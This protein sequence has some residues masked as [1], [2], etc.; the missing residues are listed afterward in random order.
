MNTT[1]HWPHHF[2]MVAPGHTPPHHRPTPENM[3]SKAHNLLRMAALGLPV[4]P[5]LV[6]GTHYTHA[7]QDCLL[8][9]YSVGLPALEEVTGRM[10][11]DPRRPLIVSVRSGAPVSMPG[12]METLLNVGLCDAT[13]PGLLRQTG[14][15]RLVWD[16]YRRLIATY[17]EVVAGV[18]GVLFEEEIACVTDRRD[19]RQLDFGELRDLSRRF[20]AIYLE[21]AG[22]PFP[23]DAKTQLNG[24]VQAVFASWSLE[25][26][27]TY[28]TIHGIDDTMGT[29]VTIQHMVFGNSGAHSGAGVGFTRNPTSGERRLWVDFLS[30][31][32]GEDVV[33]GQRNAHGHEAMA[34][35]A[36]EAWAELQ[37]IADRLERTFQD[38][39]DFEF[40]VQDGMLYMLQTRAGKRTPQ[41]TTRIALDLFDERLIEAAM[42]LQRT[43]AVQEDDLA[44][45]HLQAQASGSDALVPVA[46]AT[47]ASNG[48][49]SAEI[50]LDAERVR[51]RAASGVATVLVR[52]D[53]QTSDIGALDSAVGLLTR[54]GA[55]TSHAAV[56]A[57]QMG[58]VCLVGCSGLSVDLAGRRIHLGEQVF[59]EGDVLTLDGNNGRIYAGEVVTVKVTDQALLKRLL[60][61]RET[62]A[63]RAPARKEA[64]A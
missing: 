10:L 60:A 32:Q 59:E 39:Q 28:R 36:P 17:G 53:A 18:P 31:A 50:A 24:A 35:A 16:A 21:Q 25:K 4:P 26:A 33:A 2:Y 9:L 1:Q 37:S 23:Q 54:R 58:K 14:N 34:K 12:M 62:Y 52:Q 19:E 57:R 45:Q 64:S 7:P 6:I 11:G 22:E 55:R 48:V 43:Q 41:A 15:P 56:V 20:L 49:V 46:E 8:P 29:A 5:A 13:L 61:L 44:T 27:R 63:S 42:A 40:T 30:N 3:G 47:A 51:Q 38:M